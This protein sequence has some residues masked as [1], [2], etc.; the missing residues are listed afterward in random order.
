MSTSTINSWT[1]G[2][3]YSTGNLVLYQGNT[4]QCLAPNTAISTWSPILAPTLWK[5]Y[6]APS[7]PAASTTTTNA[8]FSKNIFAYFTEWSIYSR[9]YSGAKI[10]V[11]KITHLVYAFMMPNFTQADFNTFMT[12]YT[13]AMG[14]APAISWDSVTPPGELTFFDVFASTQATTG[15]VSGGNIGYLKYLKAQNPNLKVLI[16][17][18][19][20]SLS[21]LFSAIS[22][23]T[24]GYSR[25][26]FAQS[27]ASFIVNNG[28]DGID[29]D[30]EDIAKQAIGYNYLDVLNDGANFVL[31][32]Q[33]LRQ[34]LD[35]ASPT[36]HLL[37]TTAA[38]CD[39]IVIP[40][41][42]NAAQYYDY[43][44]LMTYDFY[45]AWGSGG[46]ASGLYPNSLQTTAITGFSTDEAVTNALNIGIPASKIC[47]GTPFY[48]RGWAKLDPVNNGP[49]IFGNPDP[50]TN[51]A[52]AATYSIV[53]QNPAGDSSWKDLKPQI[54]T[55]L[56]EMWDPVSQA[57]YCTNL[58]TGETWTYDNIQAIT[59]KTN[60]ITNKGLAGIICWELSDD[61]PTTDPNNLLNAVYTAF[62][63]PASSTTP[64]VT[65]TP[66]P[67][68]ITP[69]P[70][71][72]V[73]PTP[74]PVIVTP[75]PSPS[76]VVTPTPTPVVVTPTP[77]TTSY[78]CTFC[79]ICSKTTN[80]PC[81]LR[82]PATTPT[83]TTSS[84]PTVIVIPTPT[85]STSGS[86]SVQ[87]WAAGVA[88]TVGTVVS[89]NGVN[90]TCLAAHTS[91]LTWTP[92]AVQSLWKSS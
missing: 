86:S 19:G 70:T 47:I 41:Y 24:H 69:T 28:F 39:P 92:A 80:T 59:A 12:A 43:I 82:I 21:M 65:P 17:V 90:Y 25:T 40:N 55:K 15:G 10:P 72:V 42:K 22:A 83:P 9:G 13:A 87:A 81:V 6:I 30:Y 34:A 33:A 53:Q 60:Y 37:L 54:G 74:T 14:F 11:N 51:P 49:I 45:G 32:S 67:V 27:C 77:T 79:T 18:G 78:R 84:S 5:L 2:T 58:Q 8:T 29:I 46:H 63:T 3:V 71:P 48:S 1:I 23:N 56:T 76:P 75:T 4:Y 62:T 38:N 44:N 61:L 64:V 88:Y 52:A 16:S 89:Y 7:N 50:N 31:L 73:T 26:T 57:S 85:P 66:S 36:K 20:W 68:V 91:I 35:A